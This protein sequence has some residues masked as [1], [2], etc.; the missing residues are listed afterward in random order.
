M[1]S[2]IGKYCRKVGEISLAGAAMGDGAREKRLLMSA[3]KKNGVRYSEI[4]APQHL[5]VNHYLL[6]C[7]CFCA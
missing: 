4:I 1:S 2:I 7:S 5:N 3:L 6:Y